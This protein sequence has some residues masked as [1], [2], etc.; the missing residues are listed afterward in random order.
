MQQNSTTQTTN[1]SVDLRSHDAQASINNVMAALIIMFPIMLFVAVKAYKGYR[2]AL[3]RKQIATLEKLWHL[4][5]KN[6]KY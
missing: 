6:K 2:I 1:N 5:V 3:L 4:D